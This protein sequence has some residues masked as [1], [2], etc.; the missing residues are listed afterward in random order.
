M[1][2]QAVP[3]AADQQPLELRERAR[4][5]LLLALRTQP[6]KDLFTLAQHAKPGSLCTVFLSLDSWISERCCA[7]IG[8]RRD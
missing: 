3:L 5:N 1:R 6:V 2:R 7:V 8:A 4:A